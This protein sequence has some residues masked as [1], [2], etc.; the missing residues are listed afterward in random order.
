MLTKTLL[1]KWI[2]KNN[3]WLWLLVGLIVLLGSESRVTSQ[4]MTI[5]SVNGT[6]M[7]VINDGQCTLIEAILSANTNQSSGNRAGECP[8]GRGDD[9]I[10]LEQGVTYT[11]STINN[12]VD[13]P[14][15]LPSITSQITIEGQ[16]ATIERATGQGVANFRIFHVAASGNLTLTGV[17]VRN[18]S[19]RNMADT[20]QHGGGVYNAGRLTIQNSTF[21]DNHSV[22]EA[23][24]KGSLTGG[25]GGGGGAGG[26]GGAI[27][28]QRSGTVTIQNST[29]SGNQAR[30]GAGGQG[31]SSG[32]E[33]GG[34]GGAGG[35]PGGAGG[36][37][38]LPGGPGAF[39]GGGGGGASTEKLG[40]VGG[41]A[42]FGG[43]GGGG[44]AVASGGG[45]AGGGGSLNGGAGGQSDSQGGAGG[46]GGAGLGGAIFNNGGTVTVA[47]STFADN[48][49]FGGQGGSGA[50]V[51]GNG[52]DGV[53]LGAAIY[54]NTG[55][56]TLQS[57]ILAAGHS[58]QAVCGLNA[59]QITSLGHNLLGDS[60]CAGVFI[61]TGD[62][63]GIDPHLGSLRNNGGQTPTYALL[64]GSPALDRF[65]ANSCGVERDQRGVVRPQGRACDS[66][67]YEAE[68]ESII[69]LR[70]EVVGKLPDSDWVFTLNGAPLTTFGPAGGTFVFEGPSGSYTLEQALNPNYDVVA[71][72]GP[73]S[74]AGNQITF[75]LTRGATLECVFTNTIKPSSVTV[76]KLVTGQPPTSDWEFEI[77]DESLTTI[78][79]PGGS[80]TV[81][82]EPDAYTLREVPKPGYTV[83]AECDNNL[84][85][86]NG[87]TFELEPGQHLDC[88]FS[89]VQQSDDSMTIINE[90]VPANVDDF[91]F[92]G[93]LGL[94]T[95]DDGEMY[96]QD[97][98]PAGA[99]TIR[100]LKDSL[101]D[102]HWSLL[103]VGCEVQEDG[104]S[105]PFFPP[106]V[107]TETDF[108]ITVPLETGQDVVC[109]FHNERSN[110]EPFPDNRHRLFLPFIH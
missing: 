50:T 33:T 54:N 30:G 10:R 8:A 49:V 16:G 24:E 110:Y 43:G 19:I 75:E 90:T 40:T 34:Q 87:V 52:Q 106:V 89:A 104:T 79:P 22:G 85:G 68:I 45:A 101:P 2:V 80:R 108:S 65:E 42:G 27:F 97:S 37:L 103:F 57:T 41:N 53:N 36:F 23:G 71:Q 35:G 83:T 96:S 21:V 29:F 1:N 70:Q 63:T 26:F 99:Y 60:S 25:G 51:Q 48:S 14:N 81:E 62:G 86:G 69:T 67:A 47:Y 59:G 46:G 100:E 74:E 55:R 84:T 3:T 78:A 7:N 92:D 95:L 6:G 15:G 39:G 91:A 61:A 66:G 72:C 56:T 102:P 105:T 107:E 76:T 58:A 77:N 64:P 18:G 38:G 17:V 82:L 31:F 20:V 73:V 11:V 88:D 28:N 4:A 98:L 9:I 109:V 13:G 5:I 44:G 93:D 32:G 12:T 94:F